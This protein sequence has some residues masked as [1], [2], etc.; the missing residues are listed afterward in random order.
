LSAANDPL[1]KTSRTWGMTG[2]LAGG[3]MVNG[4]VLRSGGVAYTVPTA[5]NGG[6]ELLIFVSRGSQP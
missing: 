3:L 4:A 1:T 5:V 6:S 2:S